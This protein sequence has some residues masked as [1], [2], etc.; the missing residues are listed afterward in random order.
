MLS[1]RNMCVRSLTSTRLR[2]ISTYF[3]VTRSYHI[4]PSVPDT[5][6]DGIL[7]LPGDLA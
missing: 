5:V 6:I 1:F 4:T 2:S 3:D 7:N